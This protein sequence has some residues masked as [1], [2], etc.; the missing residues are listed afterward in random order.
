MHPFKPGISLKLPLA[1][2]TP[3]ATPH[4]RT[5]PCTAIAVALL[6]AAVAGCGRA[7]DPDVPSP[8]AGDSNAVPVTTATVT[9]TLPPCDGPCPMTAS[10]VSGVYVLVERNGRPLPSTMHYYPDPQTPGRRCTA[11]VE[12]DTVTLREDGT[13]E[14]RESGRNWCNDMPTPTVST[15]GSLHGHFALHGPRGDTIAMG[16]TAVDPPVRLE[17]VVIGSELRLVTT[18]EPTRISFRYLRQR[19]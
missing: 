8:A 5:L 3:A 10:D 14:Q 17:G 4:M 15:A 6:A 7:P 1:A 13:F 12:S 11:I 19:D 18:S 16:I 2:F 9:D